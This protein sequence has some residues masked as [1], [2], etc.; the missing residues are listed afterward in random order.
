MVLFPI[1]LA[2]MQMQAETDGKDA[3]TYFASTDEVKEEMATLSARAALPTVGEAVLE[4]TKI[5][6]A[7]A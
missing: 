5:S 4:E 3:P 2:Q 6:T 1:V 7:A